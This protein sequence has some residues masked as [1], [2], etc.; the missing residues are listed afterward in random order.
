M[1]ANNIPDIWGDLWNTPQFKT[2]IGY[3]KLLDAISN[4]P[5]SWQTYPPYNLR[6][7]SDNVYVLE[8]AVAGFGS[9]DLDVSLENGRLTVSG[10][11]AETDGPRNY[12]HRG[13]AARKFKRS[14]NL[15]ENVVVNGAELNN[16]MLIITLEHIIPDHMKPRK[17]EISTSGNTAPELLVEG[18]E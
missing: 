18:D 9:T 3:D 16:G 12:V 10:E 1:T 6:Q 7:E 5:S 15:A 13:I 8:L 4:N 2:S 14:F 17:I 11:A